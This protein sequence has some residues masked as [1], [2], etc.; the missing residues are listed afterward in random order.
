MY[1]V[2]LSPWDVECKHEVLDPLVKHTDRVHTVLLSV[3]LDSQRLASGSCDCSVV[4][5][6]AETGSTILVNVQDT[7][8][9]G[10]CPG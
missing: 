6:S 5:W 2:A 7:A 9:L 4:M 8:G 10:A 3:S 1:S